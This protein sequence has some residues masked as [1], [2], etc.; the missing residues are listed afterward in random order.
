MS[1]KKKK[2]NKNDYEFYDSMF[3]PKEMN[4]IAD[5]LEMYLEHYDTFIIRDKSDEAEYKKA[6]KTIKKGIKDIR[7]GRYSKVINPERFEDYMNRRSKMG[8]SDND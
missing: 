7:E 4:M 8:N 6:V 5:S 3:D 1:K 2:K